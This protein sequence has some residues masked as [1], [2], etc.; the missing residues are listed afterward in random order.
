[1]LYGP[2]FLA[3]LVL[4]IIA[5]AQGRIGSGIVLL[6]A[7]VAVPSISFASIVVFKVGEN[8]AERNRAKA[9]ALAHLLLEDVTSATGSN[10]MYFEGTVRNTGTSEVKYVM[11]EVEWLDASDNVL[12][13]D[14]T[15]AV[16]GKALRPGGAKS[17]QITTAVDS[18]MT[19]YRYYIVRD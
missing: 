14:R 6:L 2:L 18:R 19:S 12:E 10:Y 9:E 17:F 5:L 4:S 11:V 15:Y 1:M 16:G 13:T 7:T 8:L 3:A